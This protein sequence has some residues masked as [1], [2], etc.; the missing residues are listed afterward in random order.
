MTATLTPEQNRESNVE[1]VRARLVRDCYAQPTP[2]LL[3]LIVSAVVDGDWGF[4]SVT[5]SR[6]S[7]VRYPD[8]KVKRTLTLWVNRGCIHSS[9]LE[10]TITVAETRK[11]ADAEQWISEGARDAVQPPTDGPQL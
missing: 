8:G 1:W 11:I 2:N 9:R 6:V 7:L 3:R 5:P 4:E 10:S